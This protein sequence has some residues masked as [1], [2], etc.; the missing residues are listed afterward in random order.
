MSLLR[1]LPQRL[2]RRIREY[3]PHGFPDVA[4]CGAFYEARARLFRDDEGVILEYTNRDVQRRLFERAVEA[5]PPHGRVLDVGCG[6]GHLFEFL[7]A[8]GVA[9]DA[10]CGIDVSPT[11]IE[12]TRARVGSRPGVSLEVRD[13]TSDPLPE[14]SHDVAYLISV[15]GY[16]IGRDPMRTMMAILGSVFAA[17]TDGLVFSHVMTGRRTRPLA[18]PTD[19]QDLAAR[20]ERE[21]GARAAIHDDGVDFTY[22]VSLRHEATEARP[23]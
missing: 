12:K 18:F 13:V 4:S 3:A 22:L 9:L 11:L 14:R 15:L 20:C 2:Q 16:P 1:F 19:P 7:E 5:L 10:Y 6:F 8:R 17:T 23:A 21:L